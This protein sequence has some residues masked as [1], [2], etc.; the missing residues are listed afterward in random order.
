MQKKTPAGNSL[1][2]EKIAV[3]DGFLL[4]DYLQNYGFS[5]YEMC[6]ISD[7]NLSLKEKSLTIQS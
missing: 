1:S 3:R 7:F 2:H 5:F 4:Y 6:T